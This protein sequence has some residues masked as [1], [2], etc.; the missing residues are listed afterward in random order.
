MVLQSPA[1]LTKAYGLLPHF[2]KYS[3]ATCAPGKHSKLTVSVTGFLPRHVY[4]YSLRRQ[5]A[6]ATKSRLPGLGQVLSRNPVLLRLHT[7]GKKDNA[8]RGN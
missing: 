4:G 2:G 3:H 5:E 7:Q 6:L 1:Y 8:V